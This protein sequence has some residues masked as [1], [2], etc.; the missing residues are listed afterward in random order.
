VSSIKSVVVEETAKI[1]LS[2]PGN[3]SANDIK[4]QSI[5]SN[6]KLMLMRP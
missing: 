1:F 5:T 2:G 6:M 4:C 3:E